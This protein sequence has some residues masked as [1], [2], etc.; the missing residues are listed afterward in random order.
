M[1]GLVI[2]SFSNHQF[3]IMG[4]KMNPIKAIINDFKTDIQFLKKLY[5]GEYNFPY[6]LKETLDIRPMLKDAQTW[7]LFMLIIASLITGMFISAKYYQRMA[8]TEIIEAQE[9]VDN[10]CTNNSDY[11]STIPKVDFTELLEKIN[12]NKSST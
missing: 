7:I 9:F 1:V 12:K 8:N 11:Y 6:T 10:H 2:T 5:K 3:L 4:V